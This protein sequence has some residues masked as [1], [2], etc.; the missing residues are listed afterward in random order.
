[1]KIGLRTIKTGIAISLAMLISSLLNI[2]YP[3]FAMIAALIAIQPTVSDSWRVGVNRMLGTFI[4]AIIGLAFVVYVPVNFVFA[5]LGIILLIYIMNKLHWNEAINIAAVVFIAVFL[6]ISQGHVNYALNRLLD[7]FIGIAIAVMINYLIYPPT[8]DRKA[9]TEIKKVSKG[10]WKFHM[11]VLDILLIQEE[12]G[13][14]ISED[15]MDHIERELIGIDKFIELQVKE[16]KVKIYG[17]NNSK[18]IMLNHK[19]VKEIYQHLLNIQ[20]VMNKGINTEIIG[21]VSEEMS[22]VKEQFENLRNIE[23]DIFSKENKVD[24][25]PMIGVIQRVKK[26]FKFSKDINQYP[27][28]EVIKMLVVIYNLEETFSKF[29]IMTSF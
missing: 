3:F 22:L 5:G 27:A 19:L 18:E 11:K 13:I 24:L 26:Q 25:T 14:I 9:I 16:E 2:E 23:I 4:G 28:D 20:G 6:N 10:I 1:M 21:L 12:Q 7:T 17:G 29:N 8:Y 15:E